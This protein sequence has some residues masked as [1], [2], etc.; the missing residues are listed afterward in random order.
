[1]YWKTPKDLGLNKDQ[2][3]EILEALLLEISIANRQNFVNQQDVGISTNGKRKC[4]ANLHA[5]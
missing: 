3:T 1:M 2:V 5:R 4:Q